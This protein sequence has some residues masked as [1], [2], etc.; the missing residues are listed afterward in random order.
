MESNLREHAERLFKGK[1]PEHRPRLRR[2]D[3]YPPLVRCKINVARQRACRYWSQDRAPME[4]ARVRPGAAR[5]GEESLR[6]GQGGGPGPRRDGHDMHPTDG[7]APLR[8]CLVR[9]GG[10]SGRR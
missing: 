9:V 1:Q 8:G 2:K 4:P 7:A 6:D 3:D 10:A 5:A